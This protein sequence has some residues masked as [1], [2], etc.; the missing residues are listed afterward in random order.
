MIKDKIENNQSF[1]KISIDN[2]NQ[3]LI[4]SDNLNC[5]KDIKYKQNG[6][7]SVNSRGLYSYV[8][9][10]KNNDYMLFLIDYR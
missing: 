9:F 5:P 6:Y 3:I 4:S 1:E 10:S 2:N 8:V 7:M